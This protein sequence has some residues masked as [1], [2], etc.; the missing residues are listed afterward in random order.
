MYV[1]FAVF[2][3]FLNKRLRQSSVILQI[4]RILIIFYCW[5]KF[6][7]IV[8][9][10]VWTIS[11]LLDF[12]IRCL[13]QRTYFL[14]WFI[15]WSLFA[16]VVNINV[17]AEFHIQGNGCVIS[18]DQHKTV[19]QHTFGAHV[20]ISKAFKPAWKR[21]K[22]NKN[23]DVLPGNREIWFD[24]FV[25]TLARLFLKNCL[26]FSN[27]ISYNQRLHYVFSTTRFFFKYFP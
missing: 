11:K 25:E 10:I 23:F 16:N 2:L 9:H 26:S 5:G 8:L 13:V 7:H 6:L 14:H 21:G 22:R 18:S 3:F 12:S 15:I 1:S 20:H 24:M 17:L 19:H 27:E 4:Q